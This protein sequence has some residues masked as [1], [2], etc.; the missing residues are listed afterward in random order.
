MRQVWKIMSLNGNS[1]GMLTR[2][3]LGN[4]DGPRLL[5]FRL[6]PLFYYSDFLP[7]EKNMRKVFYVSELMRIFVVKC[8]KMNDSILD[9]MYRKLL[10]LETQNPIKIS[11][12]QS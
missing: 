2:K 3:L 9:E 7:N 1:R 4:I 12:T 5:S 8:D 6:K 11:S 10:L